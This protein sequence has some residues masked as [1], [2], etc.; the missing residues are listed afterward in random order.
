MMTSF[1]HLPQPQ[2]KQLI[3]IVQRIVRAIS[4]NKVICYGSRV[5]AIDKWNNFH[6]ED[7]CKS[8]TSAAYEFLII[9]NDDE[10]KVDHETIQIAEQQ[11]APLGCTITVIV[12]KLS[13]ANQSL[14]K[15]SRFI[16]TVYRKGVLVYDSDGTPLVLPPEEPDITI[17]IKQIETNWNRGI[18]I[19]QC[20]FKTATYCI[21][22]GWY[23]QATFDLHQSAQHACMAILRALSGYRANTHNLTRLLALIASFSQAPAAVFPRVTKEETELY[24]ILNRAY[25][26]AR[27]NEKYSVS[28]EAVGILMERVADLLAVAQKLYDE[29]LHSFKN[30]QVLS[31][32]LNA[33]NELA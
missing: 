21:E 20:F 11:A 26:E 29:K 19:A 8:V 27:Y 4:P 22:N 28:L 13:V 23:E 9:T 25:S 3:Q 10:K 6:E 16:S 18:G 32:P 31:F 17:L 7:T 5:S 30:S 33:G 15:G 12:Q 14:E 24:N 1:Q 2:V